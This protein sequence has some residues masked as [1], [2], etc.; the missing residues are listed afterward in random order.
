MMRKMDS[1]A[2]GSLFLRST[3]TV[4]LNQRFSQVLVDQRTRSRRGR[5]SSAVL[6]LTRDSC[7]CKTRRSVWTRLGWQQVTRRFSTYRLRG[8]WSFRNKYRWRTG[9]ISTYRGRGNLQRRFVRK[10]NVK[11]LPAGRT[12]LRRGGATASRGRGLSRAQVPTRSELDAE[13]DDYMS[14][15]RSR[16]DAQLDDYMA[17]AGQTSPAAPWIEAAAAWSEAAAPWSEAAAPWSEAAA[18]PVFPPV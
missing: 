3:S 13:L 17:K 9:F 14:M 7:Q 18:A 15:S 5:G 1:S 10:R 2:A 11:K 12:H 6:L 4:S 16:L 8:F